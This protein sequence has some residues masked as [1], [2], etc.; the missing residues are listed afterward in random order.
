VNVPIKL[1][2][3]YHEKK[4]SFLI[5]LILGNNSLKSDF[6]KKIQEIYIYEKC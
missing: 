4:R 3:S 6:Y 5:I 2:I 1:T